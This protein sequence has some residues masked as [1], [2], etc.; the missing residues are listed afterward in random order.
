[1][2]TTF[3]RGHEWAQ[4]HPSRSVLAE[5]ID[6]CERTWPDNSSWTF[7]VTRP[8]RTDSAESA[9]E[10][11]QLIGADHVIGAATGLRMYVFGASDADDAAPLRGLSFDWY[12]DHA[13]AS[14]TGTDEIAVG[15]L[16]ETVGSVLEAGAQHEDP[17]AAALDDASSS[18]HLEVERR[19]NELALAVE[20]LER[21]RLATTETSTLALDRVRFVGT[22]ND[23]C[24]LIRAVADQLHQATGSIDGVD[25][26]LTEHPTRTVMVQR[27][28]DLNM[29]ADRDVD[30][31]RHLS[32][33]LTH[34]A[35]GEPSTSVSLHFSRRRAATSY[36]G[37][38][39][40]GPHEAQL[41][42]LRAATNDLL[43]SRCESSRI[44]PALQIGSWIV[45]LALVVEALL[46]ELVPLGVWIALLG[47]ALAMS[48]SPFYLPS[49]ELLRPDQKPRWS[50]WSK[51]II[52]A[53][54]VPIIVN[55]ITEYARL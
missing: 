19:Q 36:M 38:H 12:G 31:F 43:H 53:I 28:E 13:R 52:L 15:V 29:I 27:V 1:M 25:I 46:Y 54:V 47:A 51:L 20:E 37:G 5:L 26:G 23:L 49:V 50:R 39:V 55:L 11:R 9:E 8:T 18:R 3:R 44:V 16:H 32:V 40:T 35:T 42:T 48:L 45:C 22:Y 14:V 6:L 21:A 33:R 7:D 24:E 17:S 4:W 30:K 34:R 2:R 10:A 41:R